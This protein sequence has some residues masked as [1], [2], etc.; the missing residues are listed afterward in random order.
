MSSAKVNVGVI[1]FGF[2]SRTFHCPLI[3][4]SPY[5]HLS[6]VVERHSDKSAQAYPGVKVV[7]SAE[8]LFG[9]NDIDLVVI[10]TPN[11]SHF[12]LAKEAMLKGKN[13]VVEKPF[14]ITSQEAEELVQVAKDTGKVCSVYQNRRWDGDF[15]TVKKLLAG[16]QLGR[17]V[18]YESHFDRFR[19]FSK[20]GWREKDDQPGSGMLYDLGAHLIDQA[21]DLFGLPKSVFATISN[22]RQLKECNVIDDFTIILEYEGHKA[23]LRSSMLARTS[24]VLR[25]SLRGMNG[26]FIKHHLDVQEEQLKNGLT[27]SSAGY[28]VED[29]ARWGCV[30]TDVDGLHWVGKIETQKGDYLSFYNNV[31]EAIL[32]KDPNHLRVKPEHGAACIRIIELAQQ[33][34]QEG[35][36][37]PL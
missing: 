27:P 22:Q 30:N 19:N 25:F 34:S 26:A 36:F 17:L 5:L 4:S 15:L 31:G 1:G 3:V 21:L 10:T 24:P 2:S 37:I 8:E 35:R 12:S 18:E 11:D 16:G 33:S 9:Q 29:E 13:V 28:G 23:F 6:A 7:K 20:A 32:K 14:T